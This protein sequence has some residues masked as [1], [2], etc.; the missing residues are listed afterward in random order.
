MDS[1]GDERVVFGVLSPWEERLT[2]NWDGERA[3]EGKFVMTVS[4]NKPDLK[5]NKMNQTS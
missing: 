2:Q 5:K 3:V 1:L 4:Q